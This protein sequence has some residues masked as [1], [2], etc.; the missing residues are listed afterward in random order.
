MPIAHALAVAGTLALVLL[1]TV[2]SARLVEFFAHNGCRGARVFAYS[3]TG[4]VV[5]GCKSRRATC[6]NDV[7]RSMRVQPGN[8]YVDVVVSDDPAGNSRDDHTEMNVYPSSSPIC[9]DTFERS[10]LRSKLRQVYRRHNGL[11]GKVS[12]IKLAWP[13]R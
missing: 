4:S 5:E 7:A 3:G 11:D 10:G 13:M 9:I 1:P 2:A 6:K 12:H 8:L